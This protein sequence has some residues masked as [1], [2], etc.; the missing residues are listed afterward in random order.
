MSAMTDTSFRLDVVSAEATLFAGDAHFVIVPGERGELGIYARHAP[1]LTRVRAGV[2]T[3]TDAQ[4]GEA[5]R[6]LVAGG[7]LEVARAGVTLIADHALRSPELDAARAGAARAAAAAWRKSHA[8]DNRRA[9]DVTAARAEW[10]EELRRFFAA[11]MHPP[12]TAKE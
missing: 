4:D 9:F 5:H 7:V 11:A 12:R 2:V 3:V 8:S 6:F 10:M 1:L